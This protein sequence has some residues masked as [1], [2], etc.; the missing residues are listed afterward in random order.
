M[1][2]S[3][4]EIAG[5][6]QESMTGISRIDM[7]ENRLRVTTHCLYPSNGL[8]RVSVRVSGTSAIVADDRAALNEAQSAGLELNVSDRS[9][10]HLVAPYGS[11]IQ[12]GTVFATAPLEAAAITVIFVANASQAVAQ[13]LYTHSRIKPTRDFRALLTELLQR[14]F[15]ADIPRA[16]LHQDVEIAG[17]HTKHKFANLIALPHGRRI[18]IDP[19]VP[20][21]ASMNSRIVAHFDVRSLGDQSI[22]Q[23]LIYDDID[24]WDADKLNLL[25]VGATPVPFSRSAHVLERLTEDA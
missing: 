14:K 7:L 12:N 22:V 25:S 21:A 5:S 20:D 18:I 16:I 19:V 15:D 17:V 4:G 6:I 1:T 13:W 8:V 9:L 23:R 10:R 3:L 24:R 2:L 11:S